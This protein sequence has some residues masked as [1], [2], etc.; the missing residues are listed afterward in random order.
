MLSA[1][2]NP[3][4]TDVAY[5]LRLNQYFIFATSLE[6]SN[7]KTVS[8]RLNRQM[9]FP[10][11]SDDWTTSCNRTV[12]IQSAFSLAMQNCF[13]EQTYER[14]PIC[15]STWTQSIPDYKHICIHQTCSRT[16]SWL[17]ICASTSC[18]RCDLKYYIIAKL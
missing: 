6:D 5:K 12:R 9:T 11:R 3:L 4:R 1:S 2:V 7:A 13:R 8:S 10:I 16:P 18:T 17:D 15:R 14:I